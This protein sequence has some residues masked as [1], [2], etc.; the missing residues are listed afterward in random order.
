[1]KKIYLTFAALVIAFVSVVGNVP[2]A[3]A[4]SNN[5]TGNWYWATWCRPSSLSSGRFDV[6][7]YDAPY[8]TQVYHYD[9]DAGWTTS[10]F[11]ATSYKVYLDGNAMPYTNDIRLTV[12]DRKSHTLTAK[13]QHG[14]TFSSCSITK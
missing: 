11:Q 10:G 8:G 7:N 13:W 2:S 5:G 4:G 1:M 9:M 6:T 14:L 12:G 3:L